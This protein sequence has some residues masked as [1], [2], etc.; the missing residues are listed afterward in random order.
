MGLTAENKIIIAA[1]GAVPPL[2]ALLTSPGA[3]VQE[4]SIW[5]LRNLAMNG[6]RTRW[7]SRDRLTVGR[8]DENRIVIAAAGA[9]ELLIDVL[10]SSPTEAVQDAASLVLL[11]LKVNL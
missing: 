6:A 9:V 10:A 11:E 7:A 8:G 2:I 4:A 5:A 1:A 3:V